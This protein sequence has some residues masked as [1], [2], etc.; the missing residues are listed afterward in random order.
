MRPQGFIKPEFFIS[1]IFAGAALPRDLPNS[2]HD[3]STGPTINLDVPFVPS[4]EAIVEAMLQLAAVGPKDLLYD[5]GSGDGRIV[6]AAARQRGARAIGV[7]LD[8]LRVA[9][10]MEDAG[11]AR[12]EHRVDFLEEDI[13]TCDF[14]DASVVTLYLLEPVNVR[15][16]PRLLQLRPGTRIVSHAFGMGDW[17]PDKTLELGGTRLFRWVVPAPVAGHWDWEGPEGQRYRVEL[18]QRYQEVTGSAWL[19]DRK[20]QFEGAQLRGRRLEL[21]LRKAPR[22]RPQ[23]FTLTFSDEGL[24]SAL[25]HDASKAAS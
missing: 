6:I 23:G 8:P 17:R 16:R 1:P 9:D 21:R 19:D 24:E 12:V 10:A 4:D 3:H 2:F 22:A 18:Q 5:L 14:S 11:W 13:F 20:I 7:E 15:L 25:D